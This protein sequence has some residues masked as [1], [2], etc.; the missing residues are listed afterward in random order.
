M[1]DGRRE[2]ARNPLS[3]TRSIM[4]QLLDLIVDL[5]RYTMEVVESGLDIIYE[6]FADPHEGNVWR[7]CIPSLQL[8][9]TAD[10]Y[11]F[12]GEVQDQAPKR[13]VRVDL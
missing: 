10:F 12:G 11:A 6:Y 7:N 5:G 13:C 9:S 4:W 8:P 3:G 2:Y 1:G